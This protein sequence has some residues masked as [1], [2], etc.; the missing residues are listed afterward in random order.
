MW[1]IKSDSSEAAWGDG[2]DD[3][4]DAAAGAANKNNR[5]KAK[6]N[7]RAKGLSFEWTEGMAL[8]KGNDEMKRQDESWSVSAWI[9]MQSSM[10]TSY[11]VGRCEKLEAGDLMACT[12][13]STMW[14][15]FQ[16]EPIV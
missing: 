15:R 4:D 11:V 5:P 12:R 3:D 6:T 10:R 14:P 13:S 2:C 1:Q 9:R 7:V 16:H 8:C